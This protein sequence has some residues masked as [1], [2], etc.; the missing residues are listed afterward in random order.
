MNIQNELRVEQARLITRRWF[1]RQ[2]GVGLGSIALASLLG[3]DKAFGGAAPSPLMPHTPH[4]KGKAK[5]VIYLFMGGAPS[6]IDL[7]D[8]KPALRK[9]NGKPVP[10]EVVIGQKYA[11]IKPDAALF[12]SDFKF[13]KHGQCG[14]ELSEALPHLAGVVDD[15]AIVKSMTTDAFNHAPGQVLMNTGTQQFGRPSRSEEHT[16]EL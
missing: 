14:A 4:F 11:F 1:F 5:R 3:A 16:S 7:F 13:S 6:Q 8:E 15:I 10:P 12:A 2:C 9:Y